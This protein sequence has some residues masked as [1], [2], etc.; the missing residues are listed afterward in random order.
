[1]IKGIK[2]SLLY[3]KLV[4]LIF[5]FYLSNVGAAT[6]HGVIEGSQ[7]WWNNGQSMGNYVALSNWKPIN[8]LTPTHEW[9]PGTFLTLPNN[10]ITLQGPGGEVNVEITVAGLE[11]ELGQASAHFTD[12]GAPMIG[13]SS[14]N[15]SEQQG[16]TTR[17]IGN[18]CVANESYVTT[19]PAI[20][21]TPFQFVRPL[22]EVDSN[23]VVQ[24]FKNSGVVSGV[25]SGM[26]TVQPVY[27]FKSNTGTWTYRYAASVPM[28][29]MIDYT[30]ASLDSVQIEGNG[31]IQPT[32]DTLNHKVSGDTL[33]NIVAKGSFT[34]GVQLTLDDVP[35]EMEFESTGVENLPYNISC[36]GACSQSQLVVD[37]IRQQPEAVITGSD[38]EVSFRLKVHYDAADADKIETGQ[39]R[40]EFSFYLEEAL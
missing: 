18:N 23:A 30:A 12:R 2:M 11:Y 13:S 27:Y 40:G 10:T 5:V 15:V 25:Y 35:Y 20:Q 29:V 34:S 26:V 6:L 28:I 21:Y 8:G 36:I 17:L 19:D 16:S 31:V 22:L 14:C 33:F 38:S 1:M 24:A 4:A 3:K 39:Y 9:L 32:Y 37:G 7:L